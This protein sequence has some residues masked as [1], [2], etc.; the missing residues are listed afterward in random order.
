[1]KGAEAVISFSKLLGKKI[2]IKNRA[3]KTYRAKE[4]DT[5]LRKTRTRSEAR[6]LHKAKLAGVACPTVLCVDEFSLYISYINGKRPKM[7]EALA[8]EA[9]GILAN[10]HTA[11][12]IHGDFTV[13][14]LLLASGKWQ[15]ANSYRLKAKSQ[16]LTAND[17]SLFVIDFG[18]GFFSN[19]I[20]DK[21]VDVLTMLKLLQ[22]DKLK[23]AFLDGYGKYEK[24]NAVLSRIKIVESRVR[25][26]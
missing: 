6:L 22:H 8:R 1:M 23:N 2:V 5:N 10:L 17:G 4:L 26:F 14:N 20:E 24:F 11:D 21:A 7:N 3:P 13:A 16:K 9:G 25:Y 19:D 15:V 12:I 18:L